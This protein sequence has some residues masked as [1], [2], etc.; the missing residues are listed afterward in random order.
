MIKILI[1]ILIGMLLGSSITYAAL[2]LTVLIS[3]NGMEVGIA[4]NPMHITIQ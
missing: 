3:G 1:G 4:A 2:R